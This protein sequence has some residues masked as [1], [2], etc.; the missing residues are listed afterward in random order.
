[1]RLRDVGVALV[2]T[3]LFVGFAAAPASA[4]S[5]PSQA[6]TDG[7]G[8]LGIGY[9]DLVTISFEV[10]HDPLNPSMQ[11]VWLCYSTTAA[12]HGDGIVGGA[13]RLDVV[14]NTG[15]TYPGVGVGVHCLPDA[16]VDV[17]PLSCWAGAGANTAPFDVTTTPAG[18]TC[19]VALNGSCQA[20]I[21]GAAVYTNGTPYPLLGIGIGSSETGWLPIPGVEVPAQC[22]G[23]LSNC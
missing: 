18:G 5:G 19:L 3:V 17:G 11:S 22:I 13:I 15:T 7:A 8:Y 9:D 16:G 1:M 20:F 14:T 10:Q 21:P 2:A 23:I 6:C 4:G 12:G